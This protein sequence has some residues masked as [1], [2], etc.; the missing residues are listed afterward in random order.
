[1]KLFPQ[2]IIVLT[3]F[4]FL[5]TAQTDSLDVSGSLQK[6]DEKEKK[7]TIFEYFSN[8]P[9]DTEVTVKTNIDSLR[10]YK[11]KNIEVNSVYS[12]KRMEKRKAGK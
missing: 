3:L 2:L 4:P 10:D 8:N 7:L 11:F 12:Y 9:D 5:L 6:K 1:M